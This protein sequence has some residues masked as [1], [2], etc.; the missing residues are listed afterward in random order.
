M[1]AIGTVTALALVAIAT[2]H[3]RSYPA[4]VKVTEAVR[5]GLATGDYAGTLRRGNPAARDA[6]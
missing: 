3:N 1:T 2:A 4:E 5:T 6:R